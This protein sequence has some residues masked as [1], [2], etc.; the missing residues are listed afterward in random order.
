MRKDFLTFGAPLIEEEEIKEVTATLRSGWLSTGSK[1]HRFEDMFKEY[2]GARFAMALN[3]C[4]AGLHLS[5]IAAGI[6]IEDEVIT[7]PMTFC[8]TANAII[9][10]GARPIFVD[11]DFDSMNISPIEVRKYIKSVYDVDKK[12]GKP[13]NKNTRK[14]LKA[15][16]PVHFAGRPC[17]MD[18]ILEIAKEYN[19]YVI[20]DAAHCVEGVYKRRKIGNIGDLT[21][22][23]FY[24]TKNIVT[25]EGG[26][27]T[28]NNKDFAEKI[29]I[30][31]L[32]GMTKGAWHR[33][34]DQGYIKYN[35]VYPGFKY[36]MM[37]MQ[38]SL[39]I[40][41]LTRVDK[42][43]KR[44]EEIWNR[45]D[46][47]FRD[48][49]I[50]TPSPIGNDIVH[51]RHLYTI[52]IDEDKAGISRD[53]FQKRL[54]KL[55]I[56]TGMHFISLH[57]HP[58]YQRAFGYK[59]GDFPNAEYI[60]DRTLSLPLSAKLTDSDVDDVIEAVRQLANQK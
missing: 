10:T 60:S 43:L 29:K 59:K 21:C 57:L 27:V 49:S 19:L 11:I 26:M 38:A 13:V 22:F 35:V 8:A 28:T 37:D 36:N 34:S 56:G 41:Q 50:A 1:V 9:H 47:A 45:Y 48:L 44:R 42:Y 18:K 6:G 14:R 53:E 15:I 4:T 25:G 5:M 30:Y 46:A 55:K 52:L 2:I 39:G 31:G 7:T 51:A 33:Y 12:T 32:H 40:H 58:F 54:Y 23:S 20:E 16:V 17:D 3:S 24:A